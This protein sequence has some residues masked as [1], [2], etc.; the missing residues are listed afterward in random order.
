M[1]ENFSDAIYFKIHKAVFVMDK[2]A[3]SSLLYKK[4]ITLSQFLILSVITDKPNIKQIEIA[5]F[6]EQTQSAVS[7]QIDILS[8][9]GFIKIVKNPE[10]RRENFLRTT[11]SG[12]KKF[13][14]SLEILNN[15]FDNLFQNLEENE[16]EKFNKSLDKILFSAC[17][18]NKNQNF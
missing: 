14:E 2:L 4:G 6:L 5:N 1:S 3:D 18:K 11:L 8:E 12:E 10:N 15:T 9:K 7:R 13:N 16:K 17:D